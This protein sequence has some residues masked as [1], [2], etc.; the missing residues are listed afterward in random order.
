M[1]NFVKSILFIL[2]FFIILLIVELLLVP[3][4]INKT[5]VHTGLKSNDNVYIVGSSH[6]Y[7]AFDPQEI[8]K[9]SGL[10]T[11]LVGSS[12]QTFEESYFIIKKLIKKPETKIIFLETY[13]IQDV[14][15]KDVTDSSFSYVFD[16]FNFIDRLSVSKYYLNKYDVQ[17]IFNFYKYHNNWKDFN[18][19][20]ENIKNSKKFM[21]IE[22]SRNY[23]PFKGFVPHENR[24][25]DLDEG[26]YKKIPD[27]YFYKNLVVKGERKIN[28]KYEK[29]LDELFEL[30][31]QRN[32]RLVL[33]TSLFY[34]QNQSAIYTSTYSNYLSKIAEKNNSYLINFNYIY[35]EL[36][37]DRTHFKDSGHLNKYGA[38]IMGNFIGNYL[39]KENIN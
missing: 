30:C 2:I 32:I 33:I 1:K 6:V 28:S 10:K 31:K 19:I 24:S 29:M 25:P 27:D 23:H 9:I 12:S 8:E 36:K 18:I 3:M 39:I 4:D 16:Y 37:L 13:M 15:Y 17:T 7:W 20:K 5:A 22:F 26:G 14:E 35:T 21:E 34:F 11:S 38:K